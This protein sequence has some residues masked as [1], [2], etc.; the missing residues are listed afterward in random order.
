MILEG[1]VQTTDLA[2][3]EG[4][5]ISARMSKNGALFVQDAA[6]RYYDACRRGNLF[7]YNQTTVGALSVSS[8]TTITGMNIYNPGSSPKA[9]AFY[10]AIITTATLPAA[11]FGFALFGGAQAILPTS[12]T[13]SGVIVASLNVGKGLPSNTAVQLQ[14]I[15][16][17][18]NVL[19]VRAISGG[20]AGAT[21]AQLTPAV[22]DVDLGGE[23]M[24]Y[25]GTCVNVQAVT[26]AVSTTMTIIGEEVPAV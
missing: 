22:I 19:L 1:R 11:Q 3:G 21:T 12:L 24:Q 17:V 18:L 8:A 14:S 5:Q 7:S 23:I 13:I 26:T 25:P 4:S 9:I 10:R 16:T 15:A 20:G 2:G 6:G